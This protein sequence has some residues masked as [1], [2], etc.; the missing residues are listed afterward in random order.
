MLKKNE[1]CAA[2]GIFFLM[3]LPEA[4]AGFEFKGGDPVA[5]EFQDS[6]E[7]AVGE[8]EADIHDF[9]SLQG[10][11]LESVIATTKIIVSEEPLYVQSGE[12][13]QESA[14]VNSK[15]PS[16]MILVNRARWT[17]IASQEVKNALALHEV[18]CLAGVED[19]GSYV[20]SGQYLNLRGIQCDPDV[21]STFPVD[22]GPFSFEKARVA[23]T[24]GKVPTSQQV[25]GSWMEVGV[26]DIPTV[27]NPRRAE[28]SEG[29]FLSGN[30]GVRVFIV[31]SK[32]TGPFGDGSFTASY[33]VDDAETGGVSPM[34][35]EDT[36]T[37]TFDSSGFRFASEGTVLPAASAADA[38]SAYFDY[39]CRL[40]GSG[41]TIL[42]SGIYSGNYD[43]ISSGQVVRY[44]LLNRDSI[45]E[46]LN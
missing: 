28:F 23:F 45:P 4:K 14:A 5:L 39:D 13:R 44:L 2:I 26:A 38:K 15:S 41:D 9:P 37:L 42:C 19:T 34:G 1:I 35:I 24:D 30:G 32:G 29:G 17:A 22:V 16:N 12:V 7:I 36:Y 10:K 8:V 27:G 11:D 6:A 40:L 25:V 21:C 3:L 20:V 33:Y 43:D 31:F 18:L 46:L